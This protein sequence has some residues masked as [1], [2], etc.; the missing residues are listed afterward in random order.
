MSCGR[1]SRRFGHIPS[2]YYCRAILIP[3]SYAAIWQLSTGSAVMFGSFEPMEAAVPNLRK[4]VL[5]PACG[6]WTQQERPAEVNA[7][8]LDFLARVVGARG[9]TS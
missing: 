1:R 2:R 3:T 8:L 7:E 9:E 4:I 6:H 5:L